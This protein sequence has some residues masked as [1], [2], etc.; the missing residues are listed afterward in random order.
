MKLF[1]SI[2]FSLMF[3]THLSCVEKKDNHAAKSE[4]DNNAEANPTRATKL[5]NAK[6]ATEIVLRKTLKSSAAEANTMNCGR[7]EEFKLVGLT[8]SDDILENCKSTGT[9]VQV[10]ITPEKRDTFIKFL[11]TIVLKPA[12]E[13]PCPEPVSESVLTLLI[14]GKGYSYRSE[15]CGS[16]GTIVSDADMFEL[17]RQFNQLLKN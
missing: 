16:G 3:I 6:D 15:E 14:A 1:H 12:A 17:A 4:S 13:A 5:E 2:I 9:P 7:V 10:S 11:S 8:A